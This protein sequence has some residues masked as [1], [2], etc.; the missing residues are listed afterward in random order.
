MMAVG[1]LQSLSKN[2]NCKLPHTELPL[3]QEK[4]RGGGETPKQNSYYFQI[5]TP[6]K[7]SFFLS[8]LFLN[9]AFKDKGS[10]EQYRLYLHNLKC[11][12][13]DVFLCT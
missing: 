3:N 8:L 6:C 5:C 13:V 2:K 7:V 1:V 4:R 11:Q 10:Q 9:L 12:N